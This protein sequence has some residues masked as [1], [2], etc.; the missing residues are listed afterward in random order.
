MAAALDN[1]GLD[2]YTFSSVHSAKLRNEGTLG[3]TPFPFTCLC[4][5]VHL[6]TQH[7]LNVPSAPGG[8]IW[9][10]T[11]HCVVTSKHAVLWL[12]GQWIVIYRDLRSVH[13][14]EISSHGL[15]A[16]CGFFA[17]LA[18]ITHQVTC[19]PTAGICVSELC[20]KSWRNSK[21][22]WYQRQGR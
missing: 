20:M 12:P 5:L 6:C 9:S 18:F 10:Q 16:V 15:W 11:R 22:W 3:S 17:Y 7:L 21:H 1:A 14:P 8:L 2:A 13:L 19:R 4:S